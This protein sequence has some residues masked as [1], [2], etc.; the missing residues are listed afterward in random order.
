MLFVLQKR[1]PVEPSNQFIRTYFS[2]FRNDPLMS[3]IETMDA[4]EGSEPEKDRDES[5]EKEKVAELNK[6]QESPT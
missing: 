4:D 1:K 2:T 6:N 3:L 5:P